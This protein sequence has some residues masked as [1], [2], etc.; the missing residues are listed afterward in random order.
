MYLEVSY[1][2]RKNDKLYVLQE[3]VIISVSKS[4]LLNIHFQEHYRLF[5]TMINMMMVKK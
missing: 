1:D 5:V 2:M 4:F 3:D